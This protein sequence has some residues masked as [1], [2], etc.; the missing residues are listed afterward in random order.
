MKTAV[1]RI[2]TTAALCLASGAVLTTPCFAESKLTDAQET[3]LE[4]CLAPIKAAQKQMSEVG[5][6]LMHIRNGKVS[7]KESVP[8]VKRLLDSIDTNLRAFWKMEKPEDEEV[9]KIV[10]LYMR[11]NGGKLS[12]YTNFMIQLGTEL[13]NK[14]ETDAELVD[15]LKNGFFAPSLHR[16]SEYSAEDLAKAEPE[17][18]ILKQ[19][20]DCA[21]EFIRTLESITN[22]EEADAA[23]PKV[24]QLLEQL[25]LQEKQVSSLSPKGK[26]ELHQEIVQTAGYTYGFPLITLEL[27]DAVD[28]ISR[29]RAC[30]GSAALKAI[31]DEI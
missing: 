17:I 24:K 12:T 7:G 5:E 27:Q 16:L 15:V 22:K 25:A 11:W 6:L 1:R 19:F 9:A 23:A 3:M 20:S 31:F 10:S 8:E 30:Y 21:R 29:K 4:Q 28:T 14:P 18:R 26:S 13:L 2:L